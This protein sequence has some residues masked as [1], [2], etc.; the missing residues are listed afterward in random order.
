MDGS[1]DN[2]NGVRGG[3]PPMVFHTKG[4]AGGTQTA[5]NGSHS[6]TIICGSNAAGEALPPHF[7]LK[8]LAKSDEDRRFSLHFAQRRKCVC[9][10]FGFDVRRNLD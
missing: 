10:C 1:L 8:T 4:L 6:P 3:R 2:T 5:N 7:Q 9:G